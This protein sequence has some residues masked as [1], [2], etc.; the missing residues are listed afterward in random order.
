MRAIV[1]KT[2]SEISTTFARVRSAIDLQTYT[3]TLANCPAS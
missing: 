3:K 1:D 2:R